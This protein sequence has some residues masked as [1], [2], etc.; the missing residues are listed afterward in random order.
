[1]V[2][3]VYLVSDD[4]HTL[5]GLVAMP[6]ILHTAEGELYG[7]KLVKHVW[8]SR[9]SGQT[10]WVPASGCLGSKCASFDLISSR[11]ERQDRQCHR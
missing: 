7:H 6:V 5:S 4:E 2:G 10:L 3:M 1:M 8:R 9:V 11:A